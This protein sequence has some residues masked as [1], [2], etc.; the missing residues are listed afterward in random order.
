MTDSVQAVVRFRQR[1]ELLD[2]LLEVADVTSETL[3]LDRLLANV[4]SIVRKV[5]P[6]E[7][8]AILLYSEKSND[9]RIRYAI[10][11]RD[12]VVRNLRI[13]LGEGLTGAAAALRQPVLVGD[14]RKDPR[15]LN[16][17]D[18]VRS[19]LAVPMVTRN[20]LVG[21]IDI[22]STRLN[23]YGEY[24]R[25]M[26]R[27]IASR[28]AAAIDNA[29]L[30]RRV[31]RQNRT[32]RTL[33]RLSQEFSSTLSLDE[34]LGRIADAVRLLIPYDSFSVLLVDE[35]QGLL[36]HR[37]SY[38]YDERARLDNIP[39]GK[40]ITGAAVATR[41]VI[42]V[43]DT[44]ADPRYIPSHP[45]I[46]SEVAVPLIARDRV[47]GVMDLESER[48]GFFTE[49]HVRTLSLLAPQVANSVENARLYEELAERERRMEQDLAAARELQLV[50]LPKEAPH[51]P[52]LET[53]VGLRPARQI[54]GDLYD[55]FVHDHEHVLVAAGDVSGKGAPA[56]L[57]GALVS[58]LLRTLAQQTCR[59]A[60]LMQAL[61]QALIERRVD[62]RY[63]TLLVL[64]WEPSRRELTMANAGS[65]PP[66]ICREGE[67]LKPR[68]EGIPL[69][70]LE[71]QEYE[72]IAICSQPG[73]LVVIYSD[74]VLDQQNPAGEEYGKRR[75]LEVL[76]QN[77]HEPP[78][79]VVEAV[80]ASL[81]AFAGGNQISDD[82]TLLVL[83]VA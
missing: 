20:K 55:F 14:V 65:F 59:P 46:R 50:L 23:A 22:Q 31:E 62:A 83:K 74:G 17:V 42:K 21:V 28:V 40:G 45:D 43:D 73:D 3:D 10:G 39:L 36:R 11:H 66:L 79:R 18:A 52:G 69:G 81:D 29:R 27:L 35:Q 4:A 67:I 47:I 32:L 2:F 38:R 25:S 9:L 7:L 60:R 70:L 24:E 71:G 82:Q 33:A 77:W 44:L 64:L 34:L 56:A 16:A 8:F 12:E 51:I 13:P 54:S 61:N 19:E 68:A 15:Y 72:E 30:Y 49:D 80:F 6:Y 48:I 26:L 76:Q 57:Y 58:G 63:V 37:F 1:S 41:Q 78:A 53:A 75:F 5:I